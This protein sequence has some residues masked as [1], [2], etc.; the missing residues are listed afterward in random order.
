M[1]RTRKLRSGGSSE[2]QDPPQLSE[3]A[4]WSGFQESGRKSPSC[5]ISSL[6]VPEPKVG[7]MLHLTQSVTSDSDSALCLLCYSTF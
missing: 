1:K 7:R 3:L 6:P 2:R 4:S 5:I